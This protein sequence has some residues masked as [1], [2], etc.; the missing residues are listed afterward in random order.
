MHIHNIVV[1]LVSPDHSH[2]EGFEEKGEKDLGRG[3]L[4]P[5]IAFQSIS[6]HAQLHAR[7]FHQIACNCTYLHLVVFCGFHCH[8]WKP[9]RALPFT[10]LV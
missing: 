2:N 9:A 4:L 3:T 6:K 1:G 7:P 10:F 8:V 5:S